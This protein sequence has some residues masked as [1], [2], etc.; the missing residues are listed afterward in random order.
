[1]DGAKDS[2]NLD[3]NLLETLKDLRLGQRFPLQ[4]DSNPKHTARATMDCFQIAQ[5]RPNSEFKV[6]FYR[7]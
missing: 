4:Q 1:M 6:A 2:E 7:S 5:S 3:E